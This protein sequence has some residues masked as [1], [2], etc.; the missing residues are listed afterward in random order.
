VIP[1][2]VVH[3]AG[4]AQAAGEDHTLVDVLNFEATLDEVSA[5][6]DFGVFSHGASSS[7]V[8]S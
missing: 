8:K 2:D 3:I 1:V 7:S 5:C 6:L 4:V